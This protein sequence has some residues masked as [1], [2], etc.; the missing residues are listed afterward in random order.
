[1]TW[2]HTGILSVGIKGHG[3]LDTFFFLLRIF[4]TV[5]SCLCLLIENYKEAFS[6]AI[7]LKK[8]VLLIGSRPKKAVLES[9]WSGEIQFC[10]ASFTKQ[11]QTKKEWL[12]G[13]FC[14]DRHL[15]NL[16]RLQWSNLKLGLKN[17]PVCICSW[18]T[19]K[20]LIQVHLKYGALV[21]R[22]APFPQTFCFTGRKLHFTGLQNK[23]VEVWLLSV[24]VSI[25]VSMWSI[26]MG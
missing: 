18:I 11:K 2:M 26:L 6:H 23:R 21:L 8:G 24:Q 12:L 3:H 7:F 1:M 25:L 13:R 16:I 9:N 19:V 20:G 14:S 10:V 15:P 5:E 22:R 4:F 17:C